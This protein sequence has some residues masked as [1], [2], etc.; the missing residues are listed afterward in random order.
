MK[1]ISQ[2]VGYLPDEKPT[3][4]KLFLYA[5]QQVI[6]MFPATVTVALITGFQVSTTIFASGLATL[7][8]ILITGKKIPLYYGSSFAYL[9][10]ISSMCAAEGFAPV[11][12]I[13]PPEAISHAQ[14]GIIFS[15]LISIAAGLLVRFCGRKAV[16]TILPPS[17][18]GPIAMIIGLTLAGNALG[19]AI[20]KVDKPDAASSWWIVVA[21]VTLLST[22]IYSKYL[23]GFLGQ[24]PLL[25]GALTG[26]AAAAI[27]HFAFGVNLFRAMPEAALNASLWKL[28][29]GSIFAV[30][31]FTLPKVSWVAVAGIM[32]IAIATIPESTAHMYQLDIYV[33]DIAKKKGKKMKYSLVDMLDRNLIGD[34]I[35]DMI[36]GVVGGPAGTNYGEN[37]STMAITKV[38][39]VPVVALAAIIAMVISFFTPL[40]QVIYGI[41]LAVIGG[42]EIYLFG[43]IAAQGIAIMIDKNVDMFSA[44][45]IAVIASIMVIGI[46]GNY[47]FGGNIPFFGIQ[48]PCIAGA[49]VFGIIL[50][51]ILSIG[52][53]KAKADEI[54]EEVPETV[55][56]TQI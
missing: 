2:A 24:L 54:P 53:K 44:K 43:A 31:A 11:D 6:V 51:A 32:P 17:I 50:N 40:I 52:E 15:G 45:N 16:E 3:A 8:F 41:P 14:F 5:V 36:S 47:A 23:K 22:I 4:W 38:F 30:P 56:K 1:K 26:C 46:G 34:G 29:D 9:T 55:D 18:T 49:A 28:G 42:L 27:A 19:D 39:S 25:L 33:N 20:P 10:A 48:V 21:L 13:L 37:I 35:C 7:C 12:G